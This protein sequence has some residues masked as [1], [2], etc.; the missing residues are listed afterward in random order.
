[1]PSTDRWYVYT[2]DFG[3]A[4]RDLSS[5]LSTE[6]ILELRVAAKDRESFELNFTIEK[7]DGVNWCCHTGYGDFPLIWEWPEHHFSSITLARKIN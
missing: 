3:R 6:D 5:S 4:L 7:R 2:G 1:M